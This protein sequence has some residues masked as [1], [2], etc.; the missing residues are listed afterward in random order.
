MYKSIADI[1]AKNKKMGHHYFN[2]ETMRFFRSKT[3]GGVIKGRYFITSEQYDDGTPRLYSLR[4]V[5][6]TGEIDTVGKFQQFTSKEDAKVFVDQLPTY[7]PE[8]YEK[9]VDTFND[10]DW[11]YF[12]KYAEI[13]PRN[14]PDKSYSTDSF[15]GACA[16]LCEHWKLV[17]LSWMEGMAKRYQK[18][19]AE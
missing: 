17:D 14:N 6:S 7:F 18:R 11:N 13:E 16:W 19:I 3:H 4:C 10:G 2:R 5:R 1:K 8:A 15:T 9:A 12:L